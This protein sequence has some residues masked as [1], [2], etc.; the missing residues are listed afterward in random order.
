MLKSSKQQQQH[1]NNDEKSRL[2]SFIFALPRV[3]GQMSHDLA[4]LT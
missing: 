4:W 1:P 2:K 3:L